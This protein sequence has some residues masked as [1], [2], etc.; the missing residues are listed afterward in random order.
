VLDVDHVPVEVHVTAKSW[1]VGTNSRLD[2]RAPA[3]VLREAT[4]PADAAAVIPV[5]RSFVASNAA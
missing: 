5:A 1:F 3:L 4:E 2:D